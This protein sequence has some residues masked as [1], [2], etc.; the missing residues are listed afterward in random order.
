[1]ATLT[2]KFADERAGDVA[3]IDDE[4]ATTW[5]ELDHRVNRLVN[6]LRG[7]GLAAGDTIAIVAGNRREWFEVALACAHGGWTYVPVN[8]HWVADELAYVF[9]DADVVAVV[10]D[11]RYADEVAAALGDERGAGVRGV[12][13]LETTGH[14][15]AAIGDHP[16]YV[17]YEELVAAASSG[18]PGDQRLGGPMFYTS[19]TTGRP[20]GVRGAL[21]G[22]AGL[23]PDIMQLVAAGFSALVPV[24]GRTLLCGPI[25]HSAQWAFSFL[26]MIAGS[27]VVMQ[28]RYDSAE[29]LDLVDRH[30]VTNVHLVPTQMKRLLDLP[31]D[32]RA[33]FDGSSLV[34][35]WHGAAPCP[36]LVKRR[37]IEWWGP[38]I[39]EYYGSTEGSIISTITSAEW[40]ERGGSVG[41]PLDTV[42]VIVVG[43]AGERLGT[44]EEGTLYFRNRMGMGFSYHNDEEKTSAAHL[45]PG[46]FTTGDVGSLDDDGY[47]WL[48]D[49]RIDMIIS[50]GVNI[51]P[52]E[53]EGVLAAHPDVADVAVI[54]VPDEEFGESVKAIV[55]VTG[56]V[57]ADDALA[58]RLIAHCREH[59]A[60]YKAPRSVDFIDEIPRTGTGKTQKKPLREPYWAGHDRRI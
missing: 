17:A 26:P 29:V 13:G 9:D 15:L 57:A 53:I 58:S 14:E 30:G 10:V 27:T 6:G 19:G 1:V 16:G 56:R 51:Y 32:V 25:Y 31:D 33:R 11:A 3:L 41:R 12:V 37:F 4:G 49:R 52:A 34:T 44:N 2:A 36:P 24:P 22:D 8:W 18:E 28:H 35:V 47:L 50:G 42:E 60:G 7:T 43:D 59:L 20:K 5:A 45:E 21:S 23:T 46:V 40:L 48:S 54:G 39:T 55:Q 38:K